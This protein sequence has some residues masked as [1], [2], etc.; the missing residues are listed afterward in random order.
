DRN[1]ELN[2]ADLT[3][4]KHYFGPYPILNAALNA[5]DDGVLDRQD[6]KAESFIFTPFYCGYDFSKTRPTANALK[7][8]YDYGYRPTKDYAYPSVRSTKNQDNKRDSSQTDKSDNNVPCG[9][10]LGTAMAISGA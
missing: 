6:R 2:L 1:D 4:D 3:S 10:F 8:N 9:P 7:K 5:S